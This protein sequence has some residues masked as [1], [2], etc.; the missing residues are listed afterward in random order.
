MSKGSSAWVKSFRRRSAAFAG[1]PTG[2]TP[3]THLN[4]WEMK[5]AGAFDS[6]PQTG[7]LMAAILA[8]RSPAMAGRRVA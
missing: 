2:E 6:Q 4:Y 8:L 3:G 7:R 1:R 5:A